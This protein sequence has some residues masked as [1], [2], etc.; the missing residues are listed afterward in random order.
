MPEK[1]DPPPPKPTT[2]HA[3]HSP[4]RDGIGDGVPLRGKV[5]WEDWMAV[6]ND[7]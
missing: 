4:N 7:E 5:F 3:Q 1:D 2:E 6:P